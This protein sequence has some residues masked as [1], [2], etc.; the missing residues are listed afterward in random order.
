MAKQKKKRRIGEKRPLN[1]EDRPDYGV[2]ATKRRK[3]GKATN[4]N[5]QTGKIAKKNAKRGERSHGRGKQQRRER[6]K[7]GRG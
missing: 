3:K 4:G 5:Q 6:S 2:S 7:K 1:M